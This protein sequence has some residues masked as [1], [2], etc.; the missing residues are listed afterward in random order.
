MWMD[1]TLIA[2]KVDAPNAFNDSRGPYFKLGL[3]APALSSHDRN[4]YI[5]DYPDDWQHTSYI[6]EI[7]IGSGEVFNTREEFLAARP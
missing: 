7:M 2:E 3:Y 6:G 5:D 1:D 4:E